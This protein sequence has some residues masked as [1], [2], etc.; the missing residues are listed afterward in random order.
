VLGASVWQ[1]SRLITVEFTRLVIIANVV[2]WPFAYYI[3][4]DWLQSFANQIDLNPLM[5]LLSAG[6][7][8]SVAWLTVGG[9]A[10]KAAMTKP[11]NSLRSE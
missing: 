3:M 9:L 2:A 11:I 6:L 4:K 5:F 8:V 10:Y 1:I 7:T